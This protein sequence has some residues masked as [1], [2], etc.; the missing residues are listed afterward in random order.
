MYLASEKLL[1][2]LSL[3]YIITK[4]RNHSSFLS[5]FIYL[6]TYLLTVTVHTAGRDEEQ[7]DEEILQNNSL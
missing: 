1:V 2:N 6:F 5:L 7:A 4:Y 3:C